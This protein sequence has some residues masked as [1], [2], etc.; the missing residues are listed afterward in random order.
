MPALGETELKSELRTR[1][2][3]LQSALSTGGESARLEGLPLALELARK[4]AAPMS[5]RGS[6]KRAIGV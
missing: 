4:T 6:P 3:R 5:S 1:R 2:E